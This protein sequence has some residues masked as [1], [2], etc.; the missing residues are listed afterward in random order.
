MAILGGV[1]LLARFEF[2]IYLLAVALLFLA[3]RILRGVDENVDPERNLLVR[4]L[5]RLMPVTSGFRG[6]RFLV[7]EDGR[8]Q[9]T[10]LLLV[11]ASVV[12]ADIAFAVDSIPAAFAITRD[13][14]LIWMA[15]AFALLGL[16]ALFVLVE[17]LL[18]RFRYLD[19][20]LAVVLA[21]VAVQLLI[22]DF[23]EIGPLVLAIV[24]GAFAVGIVA[25][26]VADRRDPPHP[27][28][29]ADRRPPRCPPAL[30]PLPGSRMG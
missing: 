15:N 24:V 9:A 20:T 26:L 30:A 12:F 22:E 25:S 2:V 23:V 28:Q 14:L 16:R 27:E 3:Y 18:R 10:P 17:A 6:R 1:A 21:F 8:R 11:L 19:E 7:N 13:P 4:G 5:R 29:V